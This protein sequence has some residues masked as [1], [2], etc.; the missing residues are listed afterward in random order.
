[1][2]ARIA[3]MNPVHN[4]PFFQ[5]PRSHVK[6]SEGMV[7]LPILYYDTSA[8]NA[9]FLV[10]Q[11]RVEAVLKGTGLSP[12]L[13]V[14]GKALVGLSCFEYRDTSVGVYNEVGLAIA[15]TP[16]GEKLALGGW[17]D[18]LSTLSHPEERHVAF[19]IID[20]PVTT[21]AARPTCWG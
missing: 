4:A 20:L 16:Q 10:E 14:G 1:M 3:P 18:L 5:V 6:T 19:H 13:T 7:E 12:S 11:A 15:V 17:R 2:N 9:F 8:L 21:A